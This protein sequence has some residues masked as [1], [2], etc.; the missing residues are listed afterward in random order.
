MIIINCNK[1]IVQN[2]RGKIN[3]TV[4]TILLGEMWTFLCTVSH[5]VRLV[6]LKM[7]QNTTSA[8]DSCDSPHPQCGYFKLSISKHVSEP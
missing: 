4:G 7:S 8:W 3:K 1:F 6:S 5:R 2:F